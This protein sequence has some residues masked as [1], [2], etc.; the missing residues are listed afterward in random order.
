MYATDFVELLRSVT[1]ADVSATFYPEGHSGALNPSFNLKRQ[2]GAAANRAISQ[3]LFDIE[4]YLRFRD[5]CV[6][7]GVD[8]EVILRTLAGLITRCS[9]DWQV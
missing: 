3:F 7:V 5:Q 9:N 2:V 4:F 6:A 8:I 1:N